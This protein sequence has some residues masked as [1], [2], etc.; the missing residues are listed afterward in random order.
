MTYASVEEAYGSVSGSNM[1]KTKLKYPQKLQSSSNEQDVRKYDME[2]H[3][4]KDLYKCNYGSHDCSVIYNNNQAFNNQQKN[5]A[6]GNLP[7]YPSAGFNSP[8]P[9]F[10]VYTLPQYP[11]Y[12][13]AKNNYMMYSPNISNMWYNNPYAY[14]PGVANQIQQWQYAH[15]GYPHNNV[16]DYYYPYQQPMITPSYSPYGFI[17]DTVTPDG[18]FSQKRKKKEHFSDSG[19]SMQCGMVYFIFFMII[20]AVIL[21]IIVI[22]MVCMN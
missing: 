4:N 10:N 6:Q 22:C 9:P 15:P 8:A 13:W 20:L 19:N 2:W 18:L 17:P 21:C 1:L 14:N 11:W 5:I 16:M 7:V 12:P 3:N